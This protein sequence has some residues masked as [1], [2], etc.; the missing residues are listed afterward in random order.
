MDSYIYGI[1]LFQS[2]RRSFPRDV[3]LRRAKHL[4]PHHKFFALLPTVV[5]AGNRGH[6]NAASR[7]DPK[8]PRVIQVL[9]SL[10]Y[11]IVLNSRSGPLYRKLESSMPQPRRG[12]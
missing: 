10:F 12:R 4:V 6:E 3:A 1:L 7:L 11:M 9:R 2:L 8:C 5:A